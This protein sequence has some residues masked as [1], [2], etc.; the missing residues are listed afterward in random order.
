MWSRWERDTL[1]RTGT[2]ATA[3]DQSC[4]KPN[5]PGRLRAP[6]PVLT[7]LSV[8]SEAGPS[9]L[10]RFAPAYG[11]RCRLQASAHVAATFR[12][13]CHSALQ[14]I[15][16]ATRRYSLESS[17]HQPRS[18]SSWVSIRKLV[19]S[20]SPHAGPPLVPGQEAR[21]FASPP[22]SA[23]LRRVLAIVQS[24]SPRVS[25]IDRGIRTS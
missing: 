14:L 21:L 9:N 20:V 25:R 11:L 17:L 6:Q 1:G 5:R 16:P 8:C 4:R 23:P 22:L 2:L 13:L 19:T 7:P 24:W 18:C 12:R 15:A 10:G 3:S